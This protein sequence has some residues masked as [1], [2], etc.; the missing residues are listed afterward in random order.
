MSWWLVAR[1]VAADHVVFVDALFA[2]LVGAG[3]VSG[4]VDAA[5]A[6][7]ASMDAWGFGLVGVAVAVLAMRRR[8]PAL[9]F[10]VSFGATVVFLLLRYPFGPIVQVVGVAI[11]SVAAWRPPRVSAWVCAATVAVFVPV[12]VGVLGAAVTVDGAAVTLAW[13][14]LPWVAGTAVRA[15]R[16]V[17]AQLV[18]AEHQR[19]AD[20]E[21]LRVAGDVHDAV[22]H[23]LTVI[24]MHAGIALHVLREHAQA[25]Q[26][27]PV[28]RLIKDASGQ[29]LDELRTALTV[30]PTVDGRPTPG[31]DRVAA[32]ARAVT[33]GRL[34][35]EVTVEGDRVSVPA[36][37]D[38][39]GYRIVQESL[40]NVLRHAAAGHASVRVC[41]EPRAVR[42]TIVDDGA[43]GSPGQREGRGLAGM[44]ERARAVGGTVQAGPKAGGGFEVHALL[45]YRA[46]AGVR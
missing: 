28:L 20:R 23:G 4:S 31:L 21:R 19:V 30:L 46:L 17:R 16:A 9:T 8:Y 13:S 14:V 10:G 2:L 39:A 34:A 32:L 43:G 29:A 1:R 22:G 7:T 40:T 33:S 37:V 45:P 5:R 38:A 44:R 6:G 15:Y 27:E 24:N 3:T 42:L 25:A 35:V 18:A 26:V 36:Q 11:Y 12:E 41:Y